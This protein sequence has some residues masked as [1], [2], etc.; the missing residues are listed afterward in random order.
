MCSFQ[1]S[2]DK[3]SS[4]KDFRLKP[5]LGSSSK[6]GMFSASCD[7]VE[8]RMQTIEIGLNKIFG[9]ELVLWL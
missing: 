1:L 2:K 6:L 8:I 3:I 7:L 4:S 5:S 9:I